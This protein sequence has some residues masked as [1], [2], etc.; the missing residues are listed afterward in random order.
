MKSE[1][2][3]KAIIYTAAV[4]ELQIIIV[5]ENVFNN[6]LLAIYLSDQVDIACS[7]TGLDNFKATIDP[8]TGAARM[9]FLDCTGMDVCDLWSLLDVDGRYFG[10]RHLLVLDHVLSEWQ[11]ENQAIHIGVRGILYE[12]H[13]IELYPRIVR[14]ILDGELWYPRK[15]LERCLL[16]DSLPPPMSNAHLSALTL[17]EKEILYLVATGMTNRDIATRL[18]ISPHTVKT[19]TYNIYKKINVS[20]RLHATLWLTEKKQPLARP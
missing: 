3:D 8:G 11:I 2:L 5:G 4:S 19:H 1:T 13:D 6:E 17:R 7:C 18:C 16:N 15:I 10:N 9:I 14:A 12:Q 20:N